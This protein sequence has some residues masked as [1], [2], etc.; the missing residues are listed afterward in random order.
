MDCC[1]N[2]W[3]SKTSPSESASGKSPWPGIR[4]DQ[5]IGRRTALKGLAT[6]AGATA[7]SSSRLAM[8]QAARVRLAFC[9]Q[10][11]CV[12]PYEVTRERGHFADEGL[13]VELVYTRG[14]SAAIQAL[15]GGAVEYAGTSFD[16]ALQ[17]YRNG[18][19]IERFASTGR[20]PLFALATSPGTAEEISGPADLVGR[21]VGVS[22]LGNADHVLVLYL[23]A[24]AGADASQV[25][26]A[27]LGT[28]LFEALRLEQIDAGMIQEP[29]LT[30][31]RE[32]GGRVLVNMMELEDAEAHLG[33]AYE[34]MGVA[35][36]REE[37]EARLDEMRALAR[38]LAKGLEDTRTLPVEEVVAALPRELVA[39]GNIAQLYDILE[40]YRESLYPQG[41]EI[42]TEAVDRVVASQRVAGLLE[43]D[44]DI[45]PLIDTSVLEN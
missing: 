2:S 25:R 32:Q 9:G 37:H 39:G 12:V 36:R 30:L 8:A 23:L 21:T 20:L 19:Q 24:E 6:L 14:G 17:A 7:V 28:N 34:F 38:A 16:A 18:A 29:A 3:P 40:R 35:V 5:G 27:T 26:F 15:V 33:G 42:D 11:L 4:V 43:E 22:A 13:E 31:V 45:S 1:G 44:F 10:L 41:V